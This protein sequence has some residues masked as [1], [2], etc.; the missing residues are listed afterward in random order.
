MIKMRVICL[1]LDVEHFM[2]GH[3]K[4]KKICVQFMHA[5]SKLKSMK[6]NYTA[7]K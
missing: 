6:A 7:A 4:K 1:I 3:S 5:T 2:A